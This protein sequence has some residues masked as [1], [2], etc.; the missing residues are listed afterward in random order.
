[1]PSW[2]IMACDTFNTRSFW[3]RRTWILIV[4]YDPLE[5]LGLLLSGM[6]IS[7]GIHVILGQLSEKTWIVLNLDNISWSLAAVIQVYL[8]AK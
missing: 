7:S 2:A 5:E 6:I 4:A 3:F 1:M 8:L